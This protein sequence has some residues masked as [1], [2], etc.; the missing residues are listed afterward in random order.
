MPL[1]SEVSSSAMDCIQ[2]GPIGAYV[3]FVTDETGAHIRAAYPGATYD[4][5][6]AIKRRY[7]PTNLFRLNQNIRPA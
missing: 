5:L 4:R 6:A 1:P 3:N 7:D 2:R